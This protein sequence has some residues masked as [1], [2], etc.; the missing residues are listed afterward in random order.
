MAGESPFFKK[1]V[2]ELDCQGLAL[3]TIWPLVNR[4]HSW[5]SL[6]NGP[7][8]DRNSFLTADY[9]DYTDTIRYDYQCPEVLPR[10][11]SYAHSNNLF[12]IGEIGGICGF[13]FGI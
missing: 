11:D 5:G 7:E 10:K 8:D 1:I 13:N 9:A 6:C 2:L 3:V 12:K 4:R